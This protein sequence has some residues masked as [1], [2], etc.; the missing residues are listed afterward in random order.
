LHGVKAKEIHV[1]ILGG[2][3]LTVGGATEQFFWRFVVGAVVGTGGY[4]A[5]NAVGGAPV[6]QGILFF[7]FV[8]ILTLI[9]DKVP[10]SNTGLQFAILACVYA[11]DYS[12]RQGNIYKVDTAGLKDLL[13]AWAFGTAISLVRDLGGCITAICEAGELRHRHR[14]STS[15]RSPSRLPA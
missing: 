7:I 9:R 4:S 10:R 5:L 12:Y 13:R 8:Y 6:A 1:Q 11:V 3:N 14:Q 15:S 2:A